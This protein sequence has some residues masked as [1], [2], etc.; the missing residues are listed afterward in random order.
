MG[1]VRRDT[2]GQE[3]TFTADGYVRCLERSDDGAYRHVRMSKRIK[4]ML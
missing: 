1:G 3:G 4:S 2:K